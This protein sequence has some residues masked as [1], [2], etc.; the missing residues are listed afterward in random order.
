MQI[1]TSILPLALTLLGVAQVVRA[2]DTATADLSSVVS[3]LGGPEAA[4]SEIGS[5]VSSVVSSLTASAANATTT[6]ETTTTS[7]PALTTTTEEPSSA[8]PPMQTSPA[9]ETAVPTGAAAALPVIHG[10]LA[11]VGLLAVLV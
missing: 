9:T 4:T 7:A 6:G 11:A 3:S 2:Q 10:G 8:S 1:P 5:L